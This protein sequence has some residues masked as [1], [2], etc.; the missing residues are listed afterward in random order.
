MFSS[1][2]LKKI[3]NIRRYS[4]PKKNPKNKK[5]INYT[6][7]V[8]SLLSVLILLMMVVVAF[9]FTAAKDLPFVFF[10]GSLHVISLLFII[11][12]FLIGRFIKSIS[13][14]NANAG[15]LAKGKLNI[16]D[17]LTDKTKGLETLTIAFNEMKRNL[18]NFIDSTKS[19]VIILSDAVDNL[20]K[21]IDMS[22]MGNEQIAASMGLVAEKSHEQLRIV[23]ETLERIQEVNERTGNI[24]K[25]LESIEAFV[26]NTVSISNAG[27]MH[28]DKYNKQIEVISSNLSDSALYIDTLDSHIN[29]IDQ[30]NGLII[31]IAEQL[32]L[33]SLNSAVEAARV[34]EAGKG[35]AVVAQ[36]MNKLSAATKDSIG[37]VDQLLSDI[38]S[39]NSKVSQSIEECVQSF[40]YSKEVFSS[41]KDSFTSINNNANILNNDIKMVFE[42]S[43][44]I[45]ENTNGIRDMGHVLHDASNEISSITEEVAG[46]TQ[47]ELAESEELRNQTHFLNNM[48]SGI[49]GLLSIYKTSIV[50]VDKVSDMPLKIAF[51]SPL[52][53]P[54]WH[55][56][57]QGAL[58]AQKELNNK[59]VE[60]VYVGFD[61][62]DD[63][64][65]NTV[66]QFVNERK[67][68]AVVFPGFAGNE[69]L[70]NAAEKYNIPIVAFNCNLP[71]GLKALSYFGPDTHE[72]ARLGGELVI[73]ALDGSG[74]FA[75]VRGGL[76]TTINSER[77]D[78]IIEATKKKRKVRLVAEIEADISD[79]RVYAA[80][81]EE[82]Q[83]NRDI[84]CLIVASGGIMGAVK[85]VE[86]LN[87][88]GKTHIITFD[89]D[90]KIID[91]IKKG[92]IYGAV[93]QDP[94]G[95]GHDP[96]IALYNYMVAGDKP[97]DITYTRTEVIDINSVA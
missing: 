15:Q 46:V 97:A 36:E 47:E 23:K 72:A 38:L 81:K 92:I 16:S 55:G 14:I 78:G 1:I 22:C 35:F 74:D 82:L 96:I 19:N 59:N 44:L 12:L 95:Q 77:R 60:V 25:S 50:P 90:D 58:Y 63:R 54:F 33:L 52:D 29:K 53:H 68:D 28:L 41:V 88:I 85:A 69:D 87:L 75:I 64:F 31:N 89:Y 65:F 61:V 17:I 80:T 32:E 42:E 86:E 49:Q 40:N 8:I 20:T 56:V 2:K 76:G 5:E 26:E 6:L 13:L 11:L 71:N 24:T 73:K 27:Y 39:S 9:L 45:N 91:L 7:L 4:I 21:S 57:R 93:G 30:V 51:I 66:R 67:A 79:D 3:F 62:V 83:K 10:S 70:V 84:K 43:R 18:M 34:G 48:L 94:F 37:K